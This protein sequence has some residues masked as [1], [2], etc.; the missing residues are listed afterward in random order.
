M[1][2]RI[3]TEGVPPMPERLMTPEEHAAREQRLHARAEAHRNSERGRREAALARF[4]AMTLEEQL[5]SLRQGGLP[6]FQ[7]EELRPL[8]VANDRRRRRKRKAG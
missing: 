8:L 4:H 2:P 5:E 1:A 7:V 3:S 6:E